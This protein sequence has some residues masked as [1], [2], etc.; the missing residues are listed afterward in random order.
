P[1]PVWF[2]GDPS[3]LAQVLTNLLSNATRHTPPGGRITLRASASGGTLQ[4]SVADTGVGLSAENIGRV[5]EMFTQVGR[6]SSGGLGIGLALVKEIVSL[7]GGQVEARSE[8]S[9]KGAEFV[10]RLPLAAAKEPGDEEAR[11][12]DESSASPLGS[13]RIL[14]VDDND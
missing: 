14:I 4:I 10:V 3:R 5:F 8:G 12:V 2:E 6:P 11:S 13:R 7:H 1:E 9:G